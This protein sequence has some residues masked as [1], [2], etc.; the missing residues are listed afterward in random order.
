MSKI[1]LPLLLVLVTITSCQKNQW[2]D[3]F[4]DRIEGH[5]TYEKAKYQAKA[6]KQEDRL[7]EF[8]NDNIYFNK[9]GTLE[10][11][12]NV[13]NIYLSGIYSFERT[14]NNND[15]IPSTTYQVQI[16]LTDT[17]TNELYQELWDQ[18]SITKKVIRYQLEEDSR[19]FNFK[20]CK[21][22]S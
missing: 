11:I 21:Q 10:I 1:L 5:W 6:F 9:D 22:E 12:N 18:F 20:L 16:S 4:T 2:K 17:A 8:K 14:T 15:D 19:P 7:D 13:D 3:R